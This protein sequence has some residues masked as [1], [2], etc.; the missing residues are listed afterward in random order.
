MQMNPSRMYLTMQGTNEAEL[1]LARAAVAAAHDDPAAAVRLRQAVAEQLRRQGL[2]TRQSAPPADPG[3]RHA[4]LLIKQDNMEEAERLLRSHLSRFPRDTAAMRLM[5]HIALKCGF[6]ENAETILRRTLEYEPGSAENIL[7]L[8]ATLRRRS[9]LQEALD[10]IE[11]GLR[12]NR[13]HVGLLTVQGSLLLH[14]G[15]TSEAREAYDRLVLL[16]PL[17]PA[18]WINV[19]YVAKALGHLGQAVAAYRTAVALDRGLGTGWMG[20]ANLKVAALHDDDIAEMREA[21]GAQVEREEE[22]VQLLFALANALDQRGDYGEAFTYFSMANALHRKAFTYDGDEMG[23]QL[24]HMRDRM[25]RDFF[26]RRSGWGSQTTDPIF[27][28]GMTR[29][30]STLVEQILASHPAIEGADELKILQALAGE[31]AA[32]GGEGKLAVALEALEP[33]RIRELGGTYVSRASH[34][35]H[36]DRPYFTDKMPANWIYAGLIHL[37]LPNAKIID[38]RRH[39][40]DCGWSNFTQFIQH[41]MAH[42]CDLAEMGEYYRYYVETIA[43]FD[44]VLPGKVHR[45]F[46]ERLLEDPEVEVRRLLA[47]LELPFD[48]ACLHFHATERPVFTPSAQQVRKPLNRDGVGRWRSYERWLEPMKTALGGVLT[49]YPG[50]PDF[51]GQ[52]TFAV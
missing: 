30:G 34:W 12:D 48:D 52:A 15:R 23:R 25:D 50:V 38:V 2:G 21:L 31:V 24:S 33:D 6:P 17:D 42:T 5:A 43:H 29:S 22:R 19:G 44:R 41:G 13:D 40:L 9:R 8:A 49:R 32:A 39:P 45:L 51:R 11:A 36:S 1:A 18:V 35:R 20:L 46:H 26:A 3:V 28:V 16:A 7:A 37:I 4:A 14:A 47:Y 27:I 10:T